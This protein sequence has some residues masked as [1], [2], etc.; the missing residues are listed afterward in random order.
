MHDEES[1]ML[2]TSL[3]IDHALPRRQLKLFNWDEQD[4][5]DSRVPSVNEKSGDVKD[6]LM[7]LD[8][9]RLSRGLG[10]PRNRNFTGPKLSCC[11]CVISLQS[12]YT[13][14]K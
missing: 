2:F 12:D 11:S 13:P 8:P 7:W 1:P 14:C 4:V 3:N 10:V 5:K 6:R 9:S